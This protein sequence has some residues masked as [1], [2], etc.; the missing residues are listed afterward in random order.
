MKRPF[1]VTFLGCLF[2][3]AG[4]VGLVYHLSAR[5][6]EQGIVLVSFVRILAI[7]GGVFLLL[8][9]AWARWLVVLWLAFHVIVSAFHSASE[10][11]AHAVLLVAVTYFLFSGA[12]AK[13]FRPLA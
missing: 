9:K 8:G 12:A 4:L 1:A 6:L 5:P 3:V 7:V 10:S 2:I 13:Y 11:T